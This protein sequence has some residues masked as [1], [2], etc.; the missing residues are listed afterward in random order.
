MMLGYREIYLDG[1][2]SASCVLRYGVVFLHT[3]KGLAALMRTLLE[4][5]VDRL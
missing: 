1:I 4:I 5:T 2:M 3:K